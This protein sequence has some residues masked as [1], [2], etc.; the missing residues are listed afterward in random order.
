MER[1]V[2]PNALYTREQVQAIDRLVISQGISTNVLMERAGHFAFKTLTTTWPDAKTIT[3][4][5]G[6]GNNGGDG[7]VLAR[8]AKQKG[9]AVTAYSVGNPESHT[10]ETRVMREALQAAGV[11]PI[12]YQGQPFPKAPILVDALLGI[13]AEGTVR[14]DYQKAIQTMNDSGYPILAID[15][16]SGIHAGTGAILGCAVRAS[17]TTTFIVLKQGLFTAEGPEYAGRV[18]LND[19]QV[20]SNLFA[21]ITPACFRLTED[22]FKGLFPKRS[23]SAHKGLFGHVLVV[24]GNYGMQGAAL[25][26]GEA[27]LSMGAGRVSIATRRE[28]ARSL[29]LACPELMCHGV[30][31]AREL[32]PLLKRVSVVAVG[33][34]LGQDRWAK[35]MLRTV[36]KSSLPLVIDADA[37][38][39]LAQ[40]VKFSHRAER[41][42]TPH[43]GEAARLLKT[44]AT[45]V[46]NDRFSAIRTLQKQYGGCVVLKGNGTLVQDKSEMI[47]LCDCGNP[48]MASAGMGDI[49]TGVIAGLHAQEIPLPKASS[50]GVY[51]HAQAGDRAAQNGERGIKA[52]DLIPYLTQ[53]VNAL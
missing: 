38:N 27:A 43:P 11:N 24:G 36:L 28:T 47:S 30:E 39:I 2:L 19:L 33:P 26:A 18:S 34:G 48:G 40:D 49:L 42:I 4:L 8:L 5:C 17:I 20:P 21:S 7:Y 23:R 1:L 46:Q 9:F 44:T 35:N 16:P 13:G 31:T 32:T 53:W 3:V 37:L 22:T 6:T 52:R 45:A 29:Y 14:L 15:I 12:A 50:L 25:L 10:P 51:L 41:V